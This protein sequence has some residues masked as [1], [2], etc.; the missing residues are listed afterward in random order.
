MMAGISSSKNS[1]TTSVHG[2][3]YR[4][5]ACSPVAPVPWASD[6]TAVHPLPALTAIFSA[7]AVN[8]KPAALA[9]LKPL[10]SGLPNSS[11]FFLTVIGNISPLACPICSGLSSTTSGHYSTRC[12]V[13]LLGRCCNGQTN[14][15]STSTFSAP[16]IPIA[17][18]NVFAACELTLQLRNETIAGL[19]VAELQFLYTNEGKE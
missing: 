9:A 15:A 3:V 7:K 1:V 8:Q 18:V 11:T 14:R 10:S 4:W 19:Q 17:L 6:D 13:R 5:S 2:L 16:Y 12:S